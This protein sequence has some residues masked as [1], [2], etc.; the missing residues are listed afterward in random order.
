MSLIVDFEVANNPRS[1]RR[2]RDNNR[3]RKPPSNA[4][5]RKDYYQYWRPPAFAGKGPQGNRPQ[6]HLDTV[7]E[8]SKVLFDRRNKILTNRARNTGVGR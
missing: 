8:A 5:K 4:V 2:G 1:G 7:A 6:V 3:R